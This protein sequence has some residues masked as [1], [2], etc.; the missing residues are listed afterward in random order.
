MMKRFPIRQFGLLAV[1]WFSALAPVASRAAQQASQANSANGESQEQE[2][3]RGIRTRE[4][5]GLGRMP[6]AK[7]AAEGAKI[8]PPPAAFAMERMLA[9]AAAPIS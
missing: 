6:D 1:V 5:L 3:A 9:V 8:S 7:M 4:F 2:D